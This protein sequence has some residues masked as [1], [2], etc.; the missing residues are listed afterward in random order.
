MT[1]RLVTTTLR[2]LVLLA[3]LWGGADFAQTAGKT[4]VLWLG[5]ATTRITT[6][7]E[8][9]DRDRSLPQ[10]QPE[11]AGQLQGPG[12]TCSSRKAWKWQ[13]A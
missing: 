2:A 3:A 8:Q 4:E 11:D 7:R 9:G 13:R 6:P 10:I 12:R 1:P 5:Q